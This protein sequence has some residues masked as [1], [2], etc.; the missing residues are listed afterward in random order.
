MNEGLVAWG[1]GFVEIIHLCGL[2]LNL[3]LYIQIEIII[4]WLLY[5][6]ERRFRCGLGGLFLRVK[7]I[8]YVLMGL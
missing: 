7:Y 5:K 4:L 2:K 1:F 8:S 6:G 3:Y